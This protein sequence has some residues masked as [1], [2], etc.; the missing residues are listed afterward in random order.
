MALLFD[1]FF[2][3]LTKFELDKLGLLPELDLSSSSLDEHVATAKKIRM[4]PRK[5]NI[6]FS[7][8]SISEIGFFCWENIVWYILTLEMAV[9][10]SHDNKP[11]FK[12]NTLFYEWEKMV[13][14][15]LSM[16]ILLAFWS[17]MVT[18]FTYNNTSENFHINMITLK[19]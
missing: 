1:F 18:T 7:W 17:D 10:D 12:K 3:T 15:S 5:T 11:Y 9:L 19:H 16:N 4:Q 6:L 2:F 13:Y 14:V 8:T